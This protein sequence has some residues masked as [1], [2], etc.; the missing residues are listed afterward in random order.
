MFKVYRYIDYNWM[1][2]RFQHYY[3]WAIFQ[4][5]LVQ[6]RMKTPRPSLTSWHRQLLSIDRPKTVCSINK[7]IQNN[8]PQDKYWIILLSD[9]EFAFKVR[10]TTIY[11][12]V[13]CR[14]GPTVRI[15]GRGFH[16]GRFNRNFDKHTCKKN[17]VFSSIHVFTIFIPLLIIHIVAV[18]MK[19]VFS[20]RSSSRIPDLVFL[21]CCS[22]R[23][24]Y[25]FSLK[26]LALALIFMLQSRVSV[27]ALLF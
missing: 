3:L 11:A 25:V 17:L 4:V 24:F 12:Y 7:F 21:I 19:Q 23:F 5:V 9:T 15:W 18:S 26:R 16:G 1:K 2:Y 27:Y 10:N 22:V 20:R 8:D 13:A 6:K 14:D